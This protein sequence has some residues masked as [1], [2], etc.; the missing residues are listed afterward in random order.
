MRS[1]LAVF[2]VSLLLLV[3]AAC[4]SEPAPPAAGDTSSGAPA[5]AGEG[6]TGTWTG[7]WGPSARDRNDVTL[8]LKWDGG[9]L[10]G[11]VNPDTQKI[12]LKS[13]SYDAGTGTIKMEADAPRGG[14]TVHFM[15]EG[16]VS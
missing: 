1:R 13:A 5:P 6:L 16:K 9:A 11:I 14:T 10:S 8:E 15:I 12:P 2:C 7:D 4:S 3:A